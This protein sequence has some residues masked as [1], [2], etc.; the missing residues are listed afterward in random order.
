MFPLSCLHRG[1]MW[2]HGFWPSRLLDFVA[3]AGSLTFAASPGTSNPRD[4]AFGPLFGLWPLALALLVLWS[5]LLLFQLSRMVSV[6]IMAHVFT[7]FIN[8]E[9]R[10][11]ALDAVDCLFKQDRFAQDKDS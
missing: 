2:H 11:D 7:T 4:L 1:I 8:L 10:P 6:S 9:S 3:F 5:F